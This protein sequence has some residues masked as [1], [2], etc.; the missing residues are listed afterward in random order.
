M[1]S[2]IQLKLKTQ[3]EVIKSQGKFSKLKLLT[4]NIVSILLEQYNNLTQNLIF[5]PT[6]LSFQKN[7]KLVKN[8]SN[9][10]N[11]L[12]IHLQPK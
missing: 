9:I 1:F 3:T 10:M 6:F 4:F 8:L 7:Y 11:L 12:I 5:Q 2:L